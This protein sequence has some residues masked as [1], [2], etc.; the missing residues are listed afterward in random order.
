M[1]KI[2]LVYLV[3]AFSACGKMQINNPVDFK[4]AQPSNS[5]L[6][7]APP[8]VSSPVEKKVSCDLDPVE[9]VLDT[10]MIGFEVTDKGSFHLGFDFSGLLK[11][12]D[13]SLAASSGRTDLAMQIYQ[14]QDLQAPLAASSGMGKFQS[15]EVKADISIEAI[16][17]GFAY[18]HETPLALM[19]ERGIDNSLLNLQKLLAPAQV[20]WSTKL[21]QV[22]N[23]TQAAIAVGKVA[24]LANGDQF[25][26]YNVVS[27]WVGAPC[28]SQYIG[29]RKEPLVPIAIAT[30]VDAQFNDSFVTIE[31]LSQTPVSVG[32]K[33][34]IKQLFQGDPKVKRA[35]LK[36][37][38]RVGQIQ[39][40]GLPLKDGRSFDLVP[41][42]S[43]ELK[44]LLE[45]QGFVLRK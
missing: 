38:I 16:T 34:E 10:Q 22:E 31:S 19:T 36:R 1:K 25:Y 13:V 12:F 3:F 42:L 15:F 24:G 23:A 39:S 14:P 6:D 45:K 27:E 29:E 33:L 43:A 17:A 4:Q 5:H 18:F 2:Y 28:A 41:Y 37:S 7:S 9:Y 26:V 8:V 32:A 44:P 20:A 30:V 11:V 40:S 21:V 35:P